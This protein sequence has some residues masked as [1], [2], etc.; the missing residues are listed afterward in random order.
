MIHY[1]IDIETLDVMDNGFILSIAAVRFTQDEIL[2]SIV[3]Y[4]DFDGQKLRTI[5]IKTVKWWM[6]NQAELYRLLTVQRKS[7]QF[8]YNQLHHFLY[9]GDK[10]TIWAKS[11]S[12]DLK[13]L[14][15]FFQ[16]ICALHSPLWEYF[17]EAD[18]R[19]AYLKLNQK[20]I[21]LLESTKPHDALEDAL[22]QARNVMEFLRL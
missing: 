12:F 8:I 14:K 17:Q 1:M 10:P 9:Q 22:A 5:E 15:H 11:P 4:P 2:D 7:S 3:L 16:Q 20:N 13:I 21:P 6:E 18:V 19:T